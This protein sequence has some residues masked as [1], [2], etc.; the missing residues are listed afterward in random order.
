[1]YY[2]MCT[3]VFMWNTRYSGLILI[4]PA[5]SWQLSL[6][7]ST[8]IAIF[9]KILLVGADLFHADGWTDITKLI[10]TFLNFAKKN[11]TNELRLYINYQLDA[12]III[13]S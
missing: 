12:L 10:A 6:S 2:H 3:Y 9:T 11:L 8:Q 1:M 13:Y 5:L 7:K 4:K